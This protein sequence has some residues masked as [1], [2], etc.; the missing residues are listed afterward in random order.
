M[1]SRPAR[2]GTAYSNSNLWE[3]PNDPVQ[4]SSQVKEQPFYLSVKWPGDQGPI[5]SLTTSYVPRG[6]QNLAAYM[7]VNADASSPEYGRMRILSMSDTTQIDGPGQSFN[8]MTTNETVAERLRPFL[9][10]GAATAT[11]GNLLTLPLGDGLLYVTP[12]YTQR[13]GST[14]SYPALRFVIV[15]F[16]QS[17]GI[18][19]TLGQALDQVFQGSSG[20]PPEGQPPT[21][22]PPPAGGDPDNPAATRALTEAQAAFEAADK[23]L[24]GGDLAAY[25]AEINKAKAAVRRALTA[26]GR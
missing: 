23:A 1:P 9:N 7:A 10:Q 15:R 20:A 16:G 11:F 3:V 22:E 5:F 14:G 13:Q 8:A 25:Q 17:V 12:V 18:G 4:A 24:S 6:R 19:D 2:P 26:L 21:E